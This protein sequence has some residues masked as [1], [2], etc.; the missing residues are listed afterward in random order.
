LTLTRI[1]HLPYIAK[2]H[3]KKQQRAFLPA[4]YAFYH[5]NYL[6][7][8]L[9]LLKLNFDTLNISQNVTCFIPQGFRKS[10]KSQKRLGYGLHAFSTS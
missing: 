3:R 6:E 4:K 2:K 5:R 10:C 8:W 1:Q 9:F 7:M